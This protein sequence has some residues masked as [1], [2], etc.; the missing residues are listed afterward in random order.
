MLQKDAVLID[1]GTAIALTL[2]AIDKP[3]VLRRGRVGAGTT[4]HR[5]LGLRDVPATKP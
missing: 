4:V 2:V 5:G 1:A 3:P